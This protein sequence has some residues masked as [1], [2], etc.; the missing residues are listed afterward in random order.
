MIISD[1]C[2]FSVVLTRLLMKRFPLLMFEEARN[3][4]EALARIPVLKPV[5]VFIDTA[6]TV[7]NGFDLTAQIKTAFPGIII[8][9]FM[10]HDIPEYREAARRCG[11]DFSFSKQSSSMVEI[12][13]L[14]ESTLLHVVP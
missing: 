4:K 7:G 2:V 14:V 8:I 1:G 9:L 6:L 5:L 10:N 13:N 12:F 3:S 11:A